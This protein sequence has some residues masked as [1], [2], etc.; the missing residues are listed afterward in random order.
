[1]RIYRNND[2]SSLYKSLFREI[3]Y[4]NDSPLRLMLQG[5]KLGFSSTGKRLAAKL[6]IRNG[7]IATNNRDSVKSLS[8]PSMRLLGE[9]IIEVKEVLEK[10]K[11]LSEKAQ[12]SKFS[13]DERIDL[14]I[15]MADLQLELYEKTYSMGIDLAQPDKVGTKRL[16]QDIIEQ[17]ARTV[18]FLEKMRSGGSATIANRGNMVGS[19]EN[20]EMV[21]ICTSD[22]V[23]D[24]NGYLKLNDDL[25][26]ALSD[27]MKMSMDDTLTRKANME[28]LFP[29]WISDE[30]VMGNMNLLLLDSES[31]T[32]STQ[33]IQE[34]LSIL[35]EVEAEFNRLATVDPKVDREYATDGSFNNRLF[36]TQMG[37]MK[38]KSYN[39]NG[40]PQDPLDVRLVETKDPISK[41]FSKIDKIFKDNIYSSLGY[42]NVYKNMEKAKGINPAQMA[43]IEG[44][45]EKSIEHALIE[46]RVEYTTL[47]LD[48]G[49]SN[50]VQLPL[51][52]A[53]LAKNTS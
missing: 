28:R 12:D 26:N 48:L 47:A 52:L 38:Y 18:F 8:D 33:K 1:M 32:K 35:K 7:E 15:E 49:L 9:S 3:R 37:V 29:K 22:Y 21:K 50:Q 40:E 6:V 39:S 46:E 25:F 20:T 13:R 27:S 10:I 24:E 4:Q 11:T 45:K 53:Q 16:H 19:T 31:A 2:P 34:K 42:G 17:H 5:D 41:L 36:L 30:D 14:Q 23:L 43:I 44:L 51:D